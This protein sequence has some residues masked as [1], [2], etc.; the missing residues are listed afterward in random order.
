MN[1]CKSLDSWPWLGFL[2]RFPTAEGSW[3]LAEPEAKPSC[4][5]PP[6]DQ[7]R[8]ISN[9]GIGSKTLTPKGFTEA[10]VRC[11]RLKIWEFSH[12]GA[13]VYQGSPPNT[14]NEPNAPL[15]SGS[16]NAGMTAF[17]SGL[18]PGSSSCHCSP[19]SK[20][21]A[22]AEKTDG[23]SFFTAIIRQKMFPLRC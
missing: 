23:L 21:K 18:V 14:R 4:L 19:N 20:S 5:L 17:R 10:D 12:Y 1:Q 9:C 8:W 2:R 7:Q 3:R 6:A 16:T 13:E 11:F 15:D 22:P